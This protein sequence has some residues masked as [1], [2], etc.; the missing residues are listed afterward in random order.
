MSDVLE[1]PPTEPKEEPTEVSN[2]SIWLALGG[3]LVVWAVVI[4]EAVRMLL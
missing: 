3:S 2:R 4:Y 1:A